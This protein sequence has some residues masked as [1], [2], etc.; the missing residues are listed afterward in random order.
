MKHVWGIWQGD[1]LLV[2][3]KISGAAVG[4]TRKI[5][6]TGELTGHKH[7]LTGDGILLED[8]KRLFVQANAATTMTHDEHPAV[9]IPAGDYLVRRQ[10]EYIPKAR[11]VAVRD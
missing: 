3:G 10:R 2:R 1:L 6:A 8:G 11:P 9:S 5:V 4:M 7:V